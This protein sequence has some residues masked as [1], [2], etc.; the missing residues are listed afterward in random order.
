MEPTSTSTKVPAEIWAKIIPSRNLSVSDL[1]NFP[2]PELA[3]SKSPVPQPLQNILSRLPPNIT[4]VEE[5]ILLPTPSEALLK[6]LLKCTEIRQSPIQTTTPF[7]LEYC[8][9]NVAM[10]R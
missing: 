4:D 3:I 7:C 6:S 10:D 1:Q 8:A 5:I 9:G 2:L